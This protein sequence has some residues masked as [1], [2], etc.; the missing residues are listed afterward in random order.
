MGLEKS[1]DEQLYND[2]V[3]NGSEAALQILVERYQENLTFF[4]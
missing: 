4:L 1:T 3:Q 2:Y